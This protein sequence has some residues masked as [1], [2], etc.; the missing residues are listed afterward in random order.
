[1]EIILAEPYTHPLEAKISAFLSSIWD[2]ISYQ[3]LETWDEIPR[4]IFE[5][6]FL[7]N[8]KSNILKEIF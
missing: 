5:I 1:L 7:T 8:Q 6:Y 3:Q 4:T 2:E